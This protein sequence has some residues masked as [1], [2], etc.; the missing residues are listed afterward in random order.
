MLRALLL[1]ALLGGVLPRLAAETADALPETPPARHLVILANADDDDSLRIARYYAER[2]SIPRDNII[3]LPMSR[4]ETI[5]W[6]EFVVSIWQPLQDELLR[7]RWLDGIPMDLIDN[8]GRRKIVFSGHSLSYLVVCRGVPLRISHD[9]ALMTEV[10]GMTNRAELRTNQSAVD[11]E[12]SLLAYGTYNIN[13]FVQNPLFAKPDPGDLVQDTVVK[14]ARLDGPTPEDVMGMIDGAIHAE[15]TG[16]IGRAYVD[17]RGPHAQG[18]EWMKAI[19]KQL[20]GMDYPTE[21]HDAP[22]TFPPEARFD[23][24]AIYF[25]WY[26]ADVN[27]P[28]KAPG[29]RFAPGAIAVHIHS[30]SAQTLHAA[31]RSWCGPFVAR[32]AAATTGAVYEPYLPLMHHLPMLLEALAKGRTL[33]EAAYYA[34]PTL[35]WENVLIGDPL[36][37]PFARSLDEQW[38]DRAKLSGRE[39]AYLTLR[40][41]RHLEQAGQ[42]AEALALARRRQREA[43]SLVVGLALA[44][45]L[46]AAGDKPG[47]AQALG[48]APHLKSVPPGD[49]TVLAAA[50]DTL[51]RANA[52]PAAVQVYDNL[53]A[54][55][56]PNDMRIPWLKLA[57]RTA[58]AARN[59]DHAIRWEQEAARLAGAVKP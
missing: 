40:E 50:A 34:L 24:P 52:A 2:R 15:R 46:L 56:L 14:V 1:L 18:N 37:R 42:A 4:A 53:F 33:G 43:P 5:S 25:G 13:A 55:E 48:F 38:S 41:M 6:R 11:S 49:F 9:P 44:E 28:F 39:A 26:A 47:A 35:S 30:Y 45:G 7:R 20:D 16:L 58:S 32:G 22:G 12:L 10:P 19:A 27:G 23:E 3:A 36:Y 31:E 29:F 8:V 51:A 59:M 21:L 57:A 54:L 17:V